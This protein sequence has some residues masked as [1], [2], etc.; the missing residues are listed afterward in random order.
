M[1]FHFP[2]KAEQIEAQ[3]GEQE[4]KTNRYTHFNELH[5]KIEISH[6]IDPKL[7]NNVSI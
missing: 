2:T 5:S 7:C 6:L 4:R 1:T 3:Y